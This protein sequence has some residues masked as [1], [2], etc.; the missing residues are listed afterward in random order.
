MMTA[1][2]ALR[3]QLCK[4][5]SSREGACPLGLW[6]RNG[7]KTPERRHCI[8]RPCPQF[9]PKLG[10]IRLRYSHLPVDVITPFSGINGSARIFG[11]VSLLL[12]GLGGIFEGRDP[13]AV[14]ALQCDVGPLG[15]DFV[16]HFACLGYS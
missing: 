16:E 11:L 2:S 9:F 10:P 12:F 8:N 6:A 1:R 13:V 3:T 7:R 5:R 15:P 14:G 4:I